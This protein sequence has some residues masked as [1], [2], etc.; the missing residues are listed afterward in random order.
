MMV[1]EWAKGSIKHSF[2]NIMLFQMLQGWWLNLIIIFK[3][4]AFLEWYSTKC[5]SVLFSLGDCGV[6]AVEINNYPGN[7]YMYESLQ[8]LKSFNCPQ[9]YCVWS[10]H[11]GSAQSSNTMKKDWIKSRLLD[12]IDMA[13][14]EIVSYSKKAAKVCEPLIPC[15]NEFLLIWSVLGLKLLSFIWFVQCFHVSRKDKQ[16]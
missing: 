15:R 1:S 6:P 7:S 12:S 8:W 2:L 10:S 3:D 13:F 4:C 14:R 5:W 11:Q 16:K 9:C